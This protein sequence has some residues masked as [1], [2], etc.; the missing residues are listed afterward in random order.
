MTAA[1]LVPARE[2]VEILDRVTVVD[3][4]HVVASR[5]L[6]YGSGLTARDVALR[7]LGFERVDEWRD[8]GNGALRATVRPL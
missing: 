5:P 2:P 4:E 8:A 7:A 1:W 3:G 6:P